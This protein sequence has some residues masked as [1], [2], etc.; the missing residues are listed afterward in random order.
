MAAGGDASSWR[1]LSDENEGEVPNDIIWWT[2]NVVVGAGVV[3]CLVVAVAILYRGWAFLQVS[4]VVGWNSD[5]TAAENFLALL[6]DGKESMVVYDDGNKMEGSIYRDNAVIDAVRLK[7]SENPNFRLSCYFNFDDDMPFTQ[8]F[9]GHPRVRIVTGHG[10]RPDGDVHYKIIDGGLKAHISRHEVASKERRY[11][12]IDCTRVPRR[13]RGHVA[14][15]LLESHKAHAS[16][17]GV[18][19]W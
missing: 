3:L 6:Q 7:L 9:E 13:W 18:G 10:D 4:T 19:V 16:S 12:V 11:R 17:V 8:A 5:K 2:V 15:V 14:D 1:G